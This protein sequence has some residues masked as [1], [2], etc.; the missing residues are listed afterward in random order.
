MNIII[1]ACL[2]SRKMFQDFF[3]GESF[4]QQVGFG[5]EGL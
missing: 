4:Y 2:Q 1:L 3:H 5:E